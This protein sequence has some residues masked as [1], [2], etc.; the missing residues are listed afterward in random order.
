[1]PKYTYGEI[2]VMLSPNFLKYGSESSR[3]RK[4]QGVKVLRRFAPEERSSTGAKVPWNESCRTFRS[5]E[6]NVP[7]NENS[8]ASVDFLLP[9]TKVQRNEKSRYRSPDCSGYN[10]K[11]WRLEV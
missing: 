6:A 2:A 8:M 1:L 4:F 7:G 11:V 3:E 10:H 5:A 9:G